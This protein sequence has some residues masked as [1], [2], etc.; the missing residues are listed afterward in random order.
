VRAAERIILGSATCPHLALLFGI[1]QRSPD[2]FKCAHIV[3]KEFEGIQSLEDAGPEF[4][5][6]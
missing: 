4:F 2:S 5:P 1:G 6:V 3:I